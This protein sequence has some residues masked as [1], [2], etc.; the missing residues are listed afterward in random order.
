MTRHKIE[1]GLLSLMWWQD[2]K[3]YSSIKA[4]YL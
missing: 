1:F 2:V 3:Q 4:T